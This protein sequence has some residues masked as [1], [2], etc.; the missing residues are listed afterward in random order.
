MFYK[1]DYI[2][3]NPVATAKLLGY[4]RDAVG[5]ILGNLYILAGALRSQRKV[6]VRTLSP[7]LPYEELIKGSETDCLTG[8]CR[9]TY[10]APLP[11]AR[12]SCC[13]PWN[14]RKRWHGPPSRPT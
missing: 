11:P 8:L 14:W 3:D 13:A 1:P 10:P 7:S 5:A 2:R 9:D 6:P 12:S 4:R